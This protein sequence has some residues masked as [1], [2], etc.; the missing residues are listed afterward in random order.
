[1]T[2]N[3]KDAAR[4]PKRFRAPGFTQIPNEIF[5]DF[6]PTMG[7]NAFKVLCLVARR[8]FGYH[9][10][11]DS[12]SLAD[13]ATGTGM[14]KSTV[15][16]AVSFLVDEGFIDRAIQVDGEGGFTPS[17]YCLSVEEEST[18]LHRNPVEG[19][20]EIR[21]TPIPESGTPPTPLR[22]KEVFK[23]KNKEREQQE[24]LNSVGRTQPITEF[25]VKMMVGKF[26]RLKGV[27]SFGKGMKDLVAE[28]TLALAGSMN[29]NDLLAAFDQFAEADFWKGW[30]AAHIVRSF[31]KGVTAYGP[32]TFRGLRPDTTQPAR[33]EAAPYDSGVSYP[34]CPPLD[35]VA[36]WNEL[37]PAKPWEAFGSARPKAY[38][39][40]QFSAR[41]D[42]VCRAAARL[43]DGGANITFGYLLKVDNSTTLYNWQVLLNGGLDWMARGSKKAGRST[44]DWVTKILD[45]GAKNA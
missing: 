4:R 28:K 32:D 44:P 16:V 30:E 19:D 18:P 12:L 37:V 31:F 35:F 5:D 1:M 24:S 29:E 21:H 3:T 7:P 26:K 10:Q 13:I 20:T 45:K 6:M 43:I 9:R 36:R 11:S 33:V 2:T 25:T 14:A 40:P 23:E 17:M 38:E 22:D 27:S 15:Q 39:D 8:T 41:F 42:E 34:A